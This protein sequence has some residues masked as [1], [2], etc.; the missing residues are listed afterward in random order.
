MAKRRSL[1]GTGREALAAAAAVE[2]AG[3]EGPAPTPAPEASPVVERPATGAPIERK[4]RVR[5]R[6]TEKGADGGSVRRAPR[7]ERA[8]PVTRESPFSAWPAAF[9]WWDSAGALAS[10]NAAL[11]RSAVA[12]CEEVVGFANARM[13]ANIETGET[14]RH[15]TSPAE[16]LETQAEYA[17]TAA[18]QYLEAPIR[19]MEL[20][21]KAGAGWAALPWRAGAGETSV[22]DS[23]AD[24]EG[25][26]R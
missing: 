2:T 13:R 17:R 14:L 7:L 20:A 18:E 4:P 6:S 1:H 19:L 24:Q 11:V 5:A 12:L 26:R 21:A 22:P 8:G 9:G 16:I 15:C 3:A 23:I 25:A 10:A